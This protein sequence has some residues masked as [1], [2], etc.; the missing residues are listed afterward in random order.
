MCDLQEEEALLVAAL[1]DEERQFNQIRRKR[2]DVWVHDINL[3]RKQQ[4]EFHKLYPELRRD[5]NRFYTYY[6]MNFESFDEILDLIKNDI[7]QQQTNFR[8][9]T[10]R[11]AVTLRFLA[12]GDSYKTI[13]HSFRLGFST[14]ATIVDE[15][16][17]AIWN[18]LQPI[19]MPEPTEEI[20][21]KSILGF[22]NV[23]QFPNCLGSI[24]G[25]HVTIKCLQKSGS[26]YFSYL[27]NFS[28][29]LMA[30]VDPEYKF[31][32]ID[33]GGYGKNSDGGIFETSAMGRK[34]ANET[35]NIPPNRPLADENEEIPCARNDNSKERFNYHLCR[36]RR[37]VE[38]AFGILAHKWRL[39]FRPLEVK[40]QTAT[41]LVKAACVLH[42]LLRTRNTD[43]QFLHLQENCN[44]PLPL[45]DNLAVDGRRAVN[46]A[47]KIREKFVTYFINL[48]FQTNKKQYL[49]FIFNSFPI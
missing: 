43:E 32:C 6:K 48:Y 15:T 46:E 3:K 18:R 34:F 45:V 24:D 31:I 37:V 1:L 40:V 27:K 4:G 33:V 23:W 49:P 47:F 13:G 5:E 30:I 26:N 11:L 41:K 28:I 22:K 14:V 42:N 10:E 20:W 29:V 44:I 36:A 17:E 9:P 16:S 7:T 38:N 25:K 19:Y 8:E 21:E 2:R 12:T 39:F 35:M